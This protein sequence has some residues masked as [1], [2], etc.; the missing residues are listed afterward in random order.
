MNSSTA[1]ASPPGT[2]SMLFSKLWRGD[3]NSE[4]ALKK[5]T[6]QLRPLTQQVEQLVAIQT[7]RRSAAQHAGRLSKWTPGQ[8]A[9]GP[10]DVAR[11]R[12]GLAA[13]C[14][15]VQRYFARQDQP[16][17]NRSGFGEERRAGRQY[18]GMG[19]AG[20]SAHFVGRDAREDRHALQRENLFDREDG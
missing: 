11:P 10:D 19:D 2:L 7:K 9:E 17:G 15:V 8:H 20:Q 5:L 1:T 6:Q 14:R 13:A 12:D 16:E 18:D 4:H 3:A